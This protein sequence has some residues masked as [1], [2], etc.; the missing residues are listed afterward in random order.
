MLGQYEQADHALEATG[1]KRNGR[2]PYARIGRHPTRIGALTNGYPGV[3]LSEGYRCEWSIVVGD[4]VRRLRNARGLTLVEMT[5]LIDKPNEGFYSPGYFSRLERGWASPP[6]Y[7]YL[8][9]AAEFGVE[10][11]RLLGPD[12]VEKQLSDREMTLVE[13][14]RRER[15]PAAEAIARV[16]RAPDPE[17]PHGAAARATDAAPP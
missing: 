3:F 1:A 14:V 11:G 17:G 13:V 4:R 5:R 2:R 12:D 7:V 10:A 15:I 9:I 16:L 8:A 6:L